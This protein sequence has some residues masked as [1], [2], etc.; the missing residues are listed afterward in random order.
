MDNIDKK[1]LELTK[2]QKIRKI[3]DEKLTIENQE[4][5]FDL[6]NTR[7]EENRKSMSRL[8]ITLLLCYFAF[9]LIIESKISEIS[10]GPFKLSDNIIALGI[11]P[12]VF[13]L[14]YYK[15]L[16]VWIDLAEQKMT[17]KI[18]ASKIFF[19]EQ[20]SFLN[21]RI[22]PY[23]FLDS[24]LLYHL[25][26]KSKSLGCLI[27]FFWIPIGLSIIVLPFVFEYYMISSLLQKFG[28]DTFLK[29]IIIIIPILISLFTILIF[30]QFG[31]KDMDEKKYI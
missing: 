19:V 14:V 18:L 16:T 8:F 31:K 6:L 1:R 15:Y 11:I 13:A 29:K 17:Y 30:I 12:S 3:L 25:E 10:F 4:R 20:K 5:Y 7:I 9:P 23:S 22:L 21:Q 24:I 28:F 2:E 26:E 27:A